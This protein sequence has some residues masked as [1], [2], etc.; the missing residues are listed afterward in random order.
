MNRPKLPD[1]HDLRLAY[2]SSLV[3]AGVVAITSVSGIL[4]WSRIYP[5]SQAVNT[6]GSDTFNLIVILQILLASMWLARRDSLIGLLIWPGALFYVLYIFAFYIIDLPITVL[7]LPYALVIVLSAYTLIAL[8]ASLDGHE[9]GQRLAGRVPPRASGGMLV[10]LATLFVVLDLAMLVSAL[11]GGTMVDPTRRV[12]WTID[13][14]IECPALLLGGILLWQ[15]NKLGYAV[16]AGL[17]LQISAL[18][19]G[20][21]ISAV[22][23]AMLTGMQGDMSTIVL[24]PIGALPAALLAI[25]VRAARQAQAKKNDSLKPAGA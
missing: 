22:L 19:I 8:T 20:V 6:V 21:P 15:R 25:F 1:K 13:L 5:T 18:I 17:L 14:I 23:G 7:F 4:F 11:A 24:L 2:L 10:G 12:A 3:I 16:G 9:I